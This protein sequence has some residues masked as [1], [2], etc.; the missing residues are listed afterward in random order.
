MS[1]KTQAILDEIKSLNC[2]ERLELV[3]R[4]EDLLGCILTSSGYFPSR[5]QPSA[6]VDSLTVDVVLEVIPPSQKMAAIKRIH[7]CTDLDLWES[8]KRVDFLP[9]I[10]QRNVSLEV[11]TTLQ[12]QLRELGA[13]VWLK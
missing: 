13:V 8:K 2:Q 10:I 5:V 4:I 9:Q 7:Q 12:K 3:Q 1:T 11:G 6:R